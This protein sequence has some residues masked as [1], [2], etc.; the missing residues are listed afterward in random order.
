MYTLENSTQPIDDVFVLLSI[1]ETADAEERNQISEAT[2]TQNP[3]SPVDLVTNYKEMTDLA[4][5]CKKDFPEFYFERQTKGFLS[6][7]ASVQNRVTIVVV[8]D[9]RKRSI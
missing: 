9:F 7:T 4:L 3:I 1:H 8:I 6:A 2:N 5:E